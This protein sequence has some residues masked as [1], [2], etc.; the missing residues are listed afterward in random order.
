MFLIFDVETTGFINGNIDY[1]KLDRF[2]RVVQLAFQLHDDRGKLIR[3]YSQ[4]VKP[5]GY[6]IP[7]N[8]AQIHKITTERALQEGIPL[9]EVLQEFLNA[10]QQTKIIAGHN[11]I[12]YDI[13]VITAELIRTGIDTAILNE[14]IVK[15]T[16]TSKEVID[17]CQLPGGKG[18]GFK[19]PK[20]EEL[21]EK[22][23]GE[24][25][26]LAHN[27]AF[28]VQANARA[29]F[30]LLKRNIIK[31]QGIDSASITYEAPDLSHLYDKEKDFH[32]KKRTST[33]TTSDKTLDASSTNIPFHFAY[34]HNHTTYSIGNSTTKIKGL[35]K[36]AAEY[37][38]SA[39]A[40]TDLGY[41]SGVIDFYA[42]IKE[43][44]K[45]IENLNKTLVEQGKD[46]LPKI[47]PII[48][49]EFY[50]C[51]DISIQNQKYHNFQIP[52][53]AKN[54][55]G[56]S[57]L[58]KLSSISFIEGFYY[59]PRIDK[60]ILLQHKEGLIV[61]S[62]WLYGEVGNTLLNRGEQQAEEVI[63]WYKENFGD[64][65]YL[66][67]NNHFLEEEKVL[68]EFLI[69]M[70]EKHQ[71]KL[72]A[73]Q[74]NFYLNQEEAD[75]FDTLLCIRNGE[76]KSDDKKRKK[77][78]LK[79]NE[80]YFKSPQQIQQLFSFY[81][82]AIQNAIELAESIETFPVE[83][84]VVL[85]KFDIPADFVKQHPDL[86]EKE[87]ENEYL[88]HLAY[89]GAERKYNP[90]TEE[91]K[92]RID[93]ELQTIAQMGFPGYFLIVSDILN[94]ARKRGIRIGPGRGSAAGSII[95]YC[96]DITN[97]DPIRYNL[98][99]RKIFKS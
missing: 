13:P 14:K 87:L 81:P 38:A 15:D 45:E 46:P 16:C 77:L 66:E 86:P 5:D 61:L 69:R 59:V 36:K 12:G 23:M 51:E 75:I 57:N 9:Q 1:S 17:F 4:I 90:V 70:S 53:L 55:I 92:N 22:L 7:Y 60:K 78:E 30:E 99:F 10:L 95:A 40:I 33:K 85:P 91:V 50:L 49:C 37:Q 18:G 29:F 96:L 52:V 24:K 94:E 76:I 54:Q 11:I 20:L 62:G 64:N 42:A 56:Y 25:F 63:L 26:E 32:K 2:P 47:K 6:Q 3:Q 97:V 93:F 41:M 48:G 31:I 88:K 83:K 8:A 82:Q 74:N 44:N 80:F 72:V 84:D 39:L 68:N 35:I 67:L 27:A 98:L 71:I 79:N 19:T 34:L 21:Y 43:K 65:F 28:D 89:K 73:A 58:C